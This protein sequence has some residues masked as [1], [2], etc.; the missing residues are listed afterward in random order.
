MLLSGGTTLNDFNANLNS[1]AY[2]NSPTYDPMAAQAAFIAANGPAWSPPPAMPAFDLGISYQA[3]TPSYQPAY[4]VPV[5]SYS[6]SIPTLPVSVGGGGG[7][8][9]INVN[10]TPVLQSSATMNLAPMQFPNMPNFTPQEQ[11]GMINIGGRNYGA[12]QLIAANPQVS[13][14]P[15]VPQM[16]TVSDG[17]YGYDATRIP[18]QPQ[19]YGGGQ[20]MQLGGEA[21][22]LPDSLMGI[23]NPYMQRPNAPIY[24]IMPEY[25]ALQQSPQR[26]LNMLPQR[27]DEVPETFTPPMERQHKT[28][29]GKLLAPLA[30]AVWATRGQANY[31]AGVAQAMEDK[32]KTDLN[33]ATTLL[34]TI[35]PGV[36]SGY[37]EVL[38]QRGAD[39]RVAANAFNQGAMAALT[40]HLDAK[41]KQML[42]AAE[43]LQISANAQLEPAL[44]GGQPNRHKAMALNFVGKQ[45]GWSDADVWALQQQQD[46]NA[47]EA[48]QQAAIKTQQQAFEL[49][50]ANKMLQGEL[51]LLSAKAAEAFGQAAQANASAGLMGTQA[52]TNKFNLKQRQ[53]IS[54]YE[55]WG[56]IADQM[57]KVDEMLVNRGT[58]Q[59]RIDNAKLANQKLQADIYRQEMEAA[60]VPVEAAG[61]M[62]SAMA[63]MGQSL[64]PS[65]KAAAAGMTDSVYGILG[66]KEKTEI[67]TD[68]RGRAIGSK[69]VPVQPPAAVNQFRENIPQPS[70]RQRF[71]QPQ[72]L[73]PSY[74]SG[75]SLAGENNGFNQMGGGQTQPGAF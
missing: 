20:P 5:Q 61:R 23:P 28:M 32:H 49:R 26:A 30:Q 33:A 4:T 43:L 71:A 31:R 18:E 19:A 25:R 34:Q 37:K 67:V 15:G 2:L 66:I 48:Q 22:A 1:A 45:L 69:M 53:K 36:N 57:N 40:F 59:N 39:Y 7:E 75:Q 44:I 47:A 8:P 41:E 68:A 13:F 74:F 12:D 65:V 56:I 10:N 52:A 46:P 3:P 70:Y 14:A 11:P 9:A 60:A 55:R 72:Q 24:G 73:P 29:A 64:D 35:M 62:A 54:K 51:S 42:R 27:S 50:K 16:D 17:A 21:E 6:A 38:Q 63:S 58:R